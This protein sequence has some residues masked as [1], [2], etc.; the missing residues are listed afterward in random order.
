MEWTQGEYVLTD[1]QTRLDFEAVCRLLADTYWAAQRSRELNAR[2]FAHSVCFS[3]L[4]RGRQVGFARAVSDW[5]TF[6][7]ICDVVIAPEHR[8]RGLGRWMLERML[9]HPAL[10]TLTQALRTRDAHRFYEAL[11]FRPVEYLRRSVNPP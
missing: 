1:D 8:G 6:C 11:G 7:W 4:W 9:E 10:Q 2:A 3:L 5:A